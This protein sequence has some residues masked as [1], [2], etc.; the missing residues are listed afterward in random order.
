MMK[1]KVVVIGAGV[2]GLSAAIRL[3]HQGY[4]VEIFEKTDQ[5]GGRMHQH[6][7][8]GYTFD[9]GPTIVMMPELY[10]EVFRQAGKNPDDYI[11][12][13]LLNPMQELHYRDGTSLKIDSHIPHFV[14]QLEQFNARDTQG[15]LAYL[16]DVYQRY[17]IVHEFLNVSYRKPSEFFNLS[18]MKKILK[19]RTLNSAYTSISRFVKDER[20]RM[21][22]SFQTLY[23]GVSPF[24]GPSI[25]TII[26][27]IE[28]LYGVWYIQGGMYAMAQAMERLFL[29]LG[30][31][32]RLNSPVDEIITSLGKV[33]GVRV[34]ADTVPADIV[35]C[36][37]DFAYAI[38]SLVP[39]L[40]QGQ[41]TQAKLAKKH[42][43]ASSF[44]MYIGLNKKYPLPVHQIRFTADFRHN[45]QQ[46]F[47]FE[48]PD[49]PSFYLY[50]PSQVDASVAPDGHELLYVLVPVPSSHKGSIEWNEQLTTKFT[51]QI[52][53]MIQEVP[54]LED[55]TQHIDY[56]KTWTPREWGELLNL[57][58]DATFGLR[59]S[60]FQSVYFRPQPKFKTLEN[61]YVTGTSVH[62]GAGVPIVLMS[63]QLV[64]AEINKDHTP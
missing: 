20:L 17:Q 40:Y 45:I 21:A 29:E 50:S 25:Y 64:V 5:V 16:A 47:D 37:A 35:V 43:S 52:L 27:M 33:S 44:M 39:A 51:Q 13:T 10:K 31:S 62:P 59:P 26:P 9:M 8:Q 11:R 15:Y 56:L 41:Y 22:L 38:P 63:A 12:M 36:N 19:M 60:L 54:G 6:R 4:Q 2:A 58:Y 55:L 23:I 49:D 24:S 14:K 3:Q 53:A 61:L 32:I 57:P 1:K 48:L 46:L 42:Y 34:G 28:L 7:A 30:G 18:T